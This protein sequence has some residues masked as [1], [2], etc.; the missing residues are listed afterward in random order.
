MDQWWNLVKNLIN[1]WFHKMQE[2]SWLAEWLLA[3]QKGLFS[4]VL[5]SLLGKIGERKVKFL[6]FLCSYYL[7]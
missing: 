1:F 4:M 3:S 2:V 6:T 7:Y 5:I